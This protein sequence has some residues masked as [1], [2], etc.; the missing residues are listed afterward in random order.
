MEG[1]VQSSYPPRRASAA[2]MRRALG[3]YLTRQS[4]AASVVRDLVLAA[5][6]A[7]SNAIIHAGGVGG[8]IC[9]AA[10]VS[11]GEAAVEVRDGGCGFDFQ[12]SEADSVPDLLDPR[13]RGLFLMQRIMDEVTV[14]CD[15]RGTTVRMVRRVA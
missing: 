12:P 11:D 13:G 1:N 14:S 8:A 5:E 4:L 2:Q 15:S 6:E 7:L 3:V 10:S 9:V